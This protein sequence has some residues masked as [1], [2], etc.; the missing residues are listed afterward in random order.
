L[1]PDRQVDAFSPW[2]QLEPESDVKSAEEALSYVDRLHDAAAYPVHTLL[3]T[4]V[5]AEGVNLQE[6]GVVVHFDLPWNPTRLIQRNGRI[7]RRLNPTFEKEGRR[8]ALHDELVEKA[9][10]TGAPARDRGWIAPGFERPEQVYHFTVLPIEPDVLR[11]GGNRALAAR[12]RESL[13]EKLEAI[14]TLF[15]LSNW[16]IVLTHEDSQEVLTGELDFETPGFRRREDLF[17]ALRQLE[18]SA[19]EANE[20]FKSFDTQLSTHIRMPKESRRRISDLFTDFDDD[21]V[22]TSWARVRAAGIVSWSFPRPTSMVAYSNQDW[23]AANRDGHGVVSGVLIIEDEEAV[24][25]YSYL[26][27]GVA[28]HASIHDTD[29][30]RIL[31][32]YVR[33]TNL[34]PLAAQA[35]FVDLADFG[36]I[37]DLKNVSAGAPTAPSELAADVLKSVIDTAVDGDGIEQ[38]QERN[39][40]VFPDVDFDLDLPSPLLDLLRTSSFWNSVIDMQMRPV[41]RA[42]DFGK[43]W[44]DVRL[45][46]DSADTDLNDQP[47]GFNLWVSFGKEV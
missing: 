4:D 29:G 42:P 9:A 24:G 1:S 37:S 45:S 43:A 20:R 30:Q 38:G 14:R 32:T 16:P 19:V 25:G 3:T 2:Y 26:T 11:D 36:L 13:Q 18:D 23:H 27:W 8:K 46:I 47:P 15:G 6:C 35:R 5:L 44:T 7:D 28:S 34:D 41:S 39:A 22:A 33:P 21:Q 10:A 40:L 12:V 31:P 17:A